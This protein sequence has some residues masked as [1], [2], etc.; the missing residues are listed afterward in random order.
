M[1]SRGS[2]W[3]L[4]AATLVGLAMLLALPRWAALVVRDGIATSSAAERAAYASG[5]SPWSWRFR[6]PD[7]IVAGRVFGQGALES[8]DDGLVVRA[9]DGSPFQIGLP[10]TRPTDLGRLD[11]LVLGA[12][13]SAVGTYGVSV[14]ETLAGPLVKSN[15]GVLTPDRLAAPLRLRDL[16][17][18]DAL[19]HAAAYPMRAAMLRIDVVL[20]AGATLVLDHAELRPPSGAIEPPTDALP[21]GLSAEGLLAWRDNLRAADPL[22]TFGNASL[23][24]VQP[25]WRAWLP[26]AVYLLLLVVMALATLRSRRPYAVKPIPTTGLFG[27]GPRLT[28]VLHASL[29]VAG[30]VWFIASLD[31]GVRVA[32]E[33]V[34]LFA[35][36]VG[37]AIFLALS[38]RLPPWRWLARGSGTA[39]PFA[40]VAVALGLALFAGHKPSWPSFGHLAA[41][42][43]WATFQ[44]WLLLAVVG[45]LLARALSRPWA[46]LLTAFA[47]ALLHTPNG[48]LM[49]LCFVAELGW[50]WWYLHHRSLLPVAVAHAASAVVLQAGLA[51]GL[52]RSLE[53]SARFLT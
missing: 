40:A 20:P 18:T 45:G 7:D 1:T 8:R 23:S 43:A 52:L 35:G 32:P 37:Y 30:P 49:Q 6:E 34:A 3:T 31:F 2:R 21:A 19:G 15:L 22:V 50:A 10:L 5:G 14:R 39:W 4:L 38:R 27:L 36:G 11:T 29:V 12:R 33:R 47:F 26:S 44:Q 48:L 16:A 28:D 13:A 9:V 51:G 42:V 25:P 46:V 41:Y 24:P 17:W 53:V